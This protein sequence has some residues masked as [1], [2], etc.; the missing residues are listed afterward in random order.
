MSLKNRFLVY[1]AVLHVALAA[2]VIPLVVI[3]RVW[4]LAVEVF[5][6]GSV[7]IGF[8]LVHGLYGSLEL[9][10]EGARFLDEQEFTTRFKQTGKP[11]LDRLVS[12]YNRLAD[13]L[14][15]ERTRLREQQHFL[16]QVLEA[17]PSGLSLI[18]I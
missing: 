6:V 7:L 9:L 14:R 5:F 16:A 10:S 11:E 18:H 2:L 3:D 17:S 8:R 13:D 1:V 15:D 4:L 12:L